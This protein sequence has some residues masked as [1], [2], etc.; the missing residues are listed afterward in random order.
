MVRPSRRRA[1]RPR[2]RAAMV[3]AGAHP[4]AIDGTGAGTAW[5]DTAA[6]RVLAAMEERRS[7]WQVWHVRAEAQRYIRAADVP[8]TQANR[9]VD[10]L[11]HKVLNGR[12]VSLARPDAIAEP[13]PL[14]RSDGASVYTVAGADLF[15]STRILDAEQRLVATAG[16]RDGHTITTAAVDM[17]LLEATANGVALNAGQTGTGSGDVNLG[18]PVAAGDRAGRHRQNNRDAGPRDRL[19]ARRRHRHR[20]RPHSCRSRG[21]ARSNPHPHAKPSPNSPPHCTSG[22]CRSGRPASGRPPWW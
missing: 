17:A 21:A 5:L 1:G 14:Q 2:R 20:A 16:R 15:T 10:L 6:D 4:R 13:K 18:C 7:T 3:R 22:S 8:A 9:L 11:V 19:A 12:S